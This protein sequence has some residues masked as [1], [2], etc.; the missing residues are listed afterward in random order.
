MFDVEKAVNGVAVQIE[1][2]RMRHRRIVP[3]LRQM[4]GVHAVRLERAV[5]RVV[6]GPA[7]RDRPDVA[8]RAVDRDRHALRDLVDVDEESARTGE[9]N[10][11]SARRRARARRN[12]PERIE[13][14]R[15]NGADIAQTV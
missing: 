3:L 9:A 1:E 7:G 8:R 15:S 4:V 6:A 10:D 14:T 5:R 2:D 13:T 12:A 11:A